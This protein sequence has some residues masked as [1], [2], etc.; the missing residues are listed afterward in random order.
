[1]QPCRRLAQRD[2]TH[3]LDPT[4]RG[5]EGDGDRNFLVS[6]PY[7]RN[8]YHDGTG[9]RCQIGEGRQSVF[10]WRESF[11]CSG[12]PISLLFRAHRFGEFGF[13]FPCFSFSFFVFPKILCETHSHDLVILLNQV[14]RSLTSTRHIVTISSQ[15]LDIGKLTPT[16][17][18]ARHSV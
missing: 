17:P 15:E 1:M 18:R 10:C 6:P 3:G 8:R 2:P 16:W 9:D 4:L 14:Y 7:I 12:F 11:L 13:S 5:I